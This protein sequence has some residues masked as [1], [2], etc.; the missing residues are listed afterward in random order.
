VVAVGRASIDRT[1]FALVVAVRALWV[2]WARRPKAGRPPRCG[3]GWDPVAGVGGAS[4]TWTPSALWLRLG[5]PAAHLVMHQR[6]RW[7]SHQSLALALHEFRMERKPRKRTKP[8]RLLCGTHAMTP[9]GS[10]AAGL[11]GS[12]TVALLLAECLAC[13]SGFVFSGA[14]ARCVRGR[15]LSDVIFLPSDNFSRVLGAVHDS[16]VRG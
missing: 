9:S 12:V 1:P 3:A 16:G 6:G 2:V 8:G 5:A 7:P 4:R 11:G 15:L 10:L 14:L 13:C